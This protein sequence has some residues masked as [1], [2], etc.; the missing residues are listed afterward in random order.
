[1]FGG[2]TRRSLGIAYRLARRARVRVT[3]RYRSKVVKRYATRRR[4]AEK[5][6]RLRLSERGLRRGDYFVEVRASRGKARQTRTLVSR[7]L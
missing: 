6:Y 2:T 1:M 3:V 4:R 7:E 5:P